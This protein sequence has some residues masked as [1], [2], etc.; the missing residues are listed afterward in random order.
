MIEG[1]RRGRFGG[2]PAESRRAARSVRASPRIIRCLGGIDSSVPAKVPV[3]SL[4]PP[5]SSKG[6]RP[7]G[8]TDKLRPRAPPGQAPTDEEIR[9]Q[10]KGGGVP[11]LGSGCPST[12]P[13]TAALLAPIA[14]A[15][16]EARGF[17]QRSPHVSW[18]QP[19]IL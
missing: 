16:A 8:D 4:R 7:W 19:L 18:I 3:S 10:R 5:R 13:G 17:Q 14:P 1:R 6:Q 9:Y 12:P 2:L 11:A 15:W